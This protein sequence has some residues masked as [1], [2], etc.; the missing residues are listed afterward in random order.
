MDEAPW[1]WAYGHQADHY[2][3]P[4]DSRQ[5]AMEDVVN[6]L[7]AG[8]DFSLMEARLMDDTGDLGD[9]TTHEELTL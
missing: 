6:E 5:R 8:D 9:V 4:F 2:S 1:W 3:G 7:E